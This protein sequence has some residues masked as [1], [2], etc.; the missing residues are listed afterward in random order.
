MK[1][2]KWGIPQPG[3]RNSDTVTETGFPSRPSNSSTEGFSWRCTVRHIQGH[4]EREVSTTVGVHPSNMNLPLHEQFYS[5]RNGGNVELL[6]SIWMNLKSIMLGRRKTT[7]EGG[8]QNN[9]T[10]VKFKNVQHNSM[11]CSWIYL[12][13]KR[14][15]CAWEWWTVV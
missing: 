7:I 5:H 1:H 2:L 12:M 6:T 9:A 8:A 15:N 11:Y 13:L 10:Y 3:D 4:L 14:E